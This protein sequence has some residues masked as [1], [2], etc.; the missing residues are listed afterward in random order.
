MLECV[1]F[2]DQ[3]PANLLVKKIIDPYVWERSIVAMLL[4]PLVAV[5]RHFIDGKKRSDAERLRVDGHRAWAE[6]TMAS[7]E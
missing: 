3:H 7:S 1:G 6:L 5:L 2:C 4:G